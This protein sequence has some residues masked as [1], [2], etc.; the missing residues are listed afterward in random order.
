MEL[1]KTENEA[2]LP[3]TTQGIADFSM[4]LDVQKFEHLYRIANLFSKSNLVPE[5]YRMQGKEDVTAVANCFIGLQM[6]MRLGMDP[7]LFLQK[8]YVVHGKPSL[9]ATVIIALINGSDRYVD[10]LDWEFSGT[11]GADNYTCTCYA[12]L[13]SSGKRQEISLTWKEVKDSGWISKSNS[14]WTKLPQL[15]FRY[16]TA[17]IF[18]RTFCPEV[19][20]GLHSREELIDAEEV[21]AEPRTSSNNELQDKFKSLLSERKES[22]SIQKPEPKET[23]IPKV[24]QKEVPKVATPNKKG[25]ADLFDAQKPE[26]KTNTIYSDE[27]EIF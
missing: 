19:M 25:Q 1:V 15:M 8:S 4:Y 14:Q 13:K 10:G 6:A 3:R 21:V 23:E 26:V 5:H 2:N 16:R 17:S 24:E 22:P 7:L 18:G 12:Q 20:F 9:E 27:S 11:F